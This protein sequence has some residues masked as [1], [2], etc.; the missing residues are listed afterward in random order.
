MAKATIRENGK[1]YVI[2]LDGK[3]TEQEQEMLERLGIIEIE[4]KPKRKRK[5][6][7]DKHR[8]TEYYKNVDNKK[9]EKPSYE[10]VEK[11]ELDEYLNEKID[12][13][14][15]EEV[16]DENAKE[17]TEKALKLRAEEIDGLKEMEKWENKSDK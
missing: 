17:K 16:C 3:Y 2:E 5:K 9:D 14:W 11:Q 13:G 10:E 1:T 8:T 4:E 12:D 7:S 6:M 15:G